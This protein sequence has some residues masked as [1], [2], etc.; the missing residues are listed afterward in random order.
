M[1]FYQHFASL[2]P[3]SRKNKLIKRQL[4]FQ[5]LFSLPNQ[6]TQKQDFVSLGNE[7]YIGYNK[8]SMTTTNLITKKMAEMTCFL[9]KKGSRKAI[10]ANPKRQIY[11][12][13]NLMSTILN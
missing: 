4:E 10:S 7:V 9:H 1:D 5:E 13:F 3:P 8:T 11:E 2:S 12:I 6:E